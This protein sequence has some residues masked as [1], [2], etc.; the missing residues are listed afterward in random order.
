MGSGWFISESSFTQNRLG[1]DHENDTG[2]KEL[3]TFGPK[4]L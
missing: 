2:I 1:F 3:K 4:N